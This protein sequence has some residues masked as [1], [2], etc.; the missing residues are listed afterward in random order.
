[1]I[2]RKPDHFPHNGLPRLAIVLLG[3]A[4]SGFRAHARFS[5]TVQPVAQSQPRDLH[6]IFGRG[7]A[8]TQLVDAS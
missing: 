4:S 6:R 1:M 7:A 5:Y 8:H 2:P 3:V